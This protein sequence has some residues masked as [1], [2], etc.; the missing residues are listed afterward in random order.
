MRYKLY[1][2]LDVFIM[3]Y[4]LITDP[5]SIQNIV[6]CALSRL[7]HVYDLKGQAG[8]PARTPSSWVRAKQKQRR[9]RLPAAQLRTTSSHSTALVLHLWYIAKAL[10]KLYRLPPDSASKLQQTTGWIFYSIQITAFPHTNWNEHEYLFLS[11]LYNCCSRAN[12]HIQ[13]I[14]TI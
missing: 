11:V 6:N 8:A 14:I 7:L 9:R 10:S 13:T 1:R 12:E 2:F 3:Q 4:V 5:N